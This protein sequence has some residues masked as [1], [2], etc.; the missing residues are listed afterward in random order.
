MMTVTCASCGAQ[1]QSGRFCA[2]C[3]AALGTPAACPSCGASLPAGGAFCN[4]CGAAVAAGAPRPPEPASRASHPNRRGKGEL[5][6]WI[7][8]GVAVG[9]L[10]AVLVL[11]RLGGSDSPPASGALDGSA[12]PTGAPTGAAAVDI[13]SMTPRERADRL[14]NRV[15]RS[16]SDGDTAQARAFLPM[17]LAAYDQ[18]PE[19]DLDGHYHHAVLHLVGDDPRSALR[20]A[21]AILAREPE[22]LFGHFTAAQALQAMGDETAAREHFQRFLDAYDAEVALDRPEYRDHAQVLPVNRDVAREALAAQ[23]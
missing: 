11:P 2:E 14:F 5:L 1:D 8:A 21:E 12:P 17:A 22:H 4:Q 6:P 19:L 7:V 10:L 20:K 16:V 18:V 3:G 23:Q 9:M 13:S 15:M